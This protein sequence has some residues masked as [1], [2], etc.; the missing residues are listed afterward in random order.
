MHVKLNAHA[1]EYARMLIRGGEVERDGRGR[2]REPEEAEGSGCIARQG[3]A[4]YS[5]W[6]LG[7]DDS[8]DSP[9]RDAYSYVYGDFRLV[10]REALL[11]AEARAAERGHEAIAEA[12][13][14]L[15]ALI[16]GGAPRSPRARERGAGRGRRL[17]DR[18]SMLGLRREVLR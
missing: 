18:V 13:R 11:A 14:Q 3:W 2:W 10:Q 17:L 5:W 9:R 8:G 6:H 16:D 15:V 7:V 4:V 12:A 1:V